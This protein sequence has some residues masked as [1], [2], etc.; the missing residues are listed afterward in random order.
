MG[1][2]RSAL[3]A[4][5]LESDDPADVLSRLDRKMHIF[6]VGAMATVTYAVI[7]PDRDRARISVAGHP[8]PILAAPDQPTTTLW[9]DPD[10]PLGVR[11]GSPRRVTEVSLPAGAVLVLYTDGLVERHGE[12]LDTGIER[13]RAAVATGTAEG[14]CARVTSA[15]I[16]NE[17]PTDDVA[18]LAIA[19]AD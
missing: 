10:L 8:P 5:A 12:L 9:I 13:L 11:A 7:A 4:Y 6:E 19:R 1:R 15:M 14:V 3:R 18:L 2:I 16:G 17:P